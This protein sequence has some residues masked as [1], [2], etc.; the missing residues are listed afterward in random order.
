MADAPSL[1]EVQRRFWESH[2]AEL[3]YDDAVVETVARRCTE[4]DAGA[5]N[6]DHI[7]THSVLPELSTLVL[8]R[9]SRGRAV[10]AVHLSLGAAGGFAYRVAD[11]APLRALPLPVPA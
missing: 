11:A 9:M 10:S 2:G 5:R 1:A 4:T 7:V 6:V 3:T 8:E